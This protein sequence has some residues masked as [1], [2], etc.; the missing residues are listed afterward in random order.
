MTATTTAPRSEMNTATDTA[1]SPAARA[2]Q[3]AQ[4]SRAAQ[5]S[6]IPVI[7]M[8][9][10]VPGFPGLQRFAL[11]QV[12]EE[13]VLCALRSLDD[14]TLRFLVV[15]P[16]RFFPAYAPVVDDQVV[17][18]LAID[19]VEDV[20][21]LVVLKPGDSLASTTANLAAPVLVNTRTHRAA[22]VILDD[23]RLSLAQPLLAS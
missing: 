16:V 21:L 23:P 15:P 14:P 11:V 7:E 13:G 18:D 2:A 6:E 17:A 1:P 9:R 22:Q 19:A 4:A 8:V 3:A 20:L 12:D 10:P 5:V